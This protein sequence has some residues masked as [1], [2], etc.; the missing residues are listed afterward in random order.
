MFLV[1]IYY[2]LHKTINCHLILFDLGLH[3][4]E[5][6]QETSEKNKEKYDPVLCDE[7]SQHKNRL[8]IHETQSAVY[9][10]QSNLLSTT[11][12][13]TPM[14]HPPSSK[15]YSCNICNKK[16]D[17]QSKLRFHHMK[18]HNMKN[19][20]EY[21]KSN[22]VDDDKITSRQ[23]GRET[24]LSNAHSSPKCNERHQKKRDKMKDQQE[25]ERTSQEKVEKPC[26][27]GPK[28]AKKGV[29]VEL[30]ESKPS[31]ELEHQG[32]EQVKDK[33]YAT[34]I[35]KPKNMDKNSKMEVS[36]PND[37]PNLAEDP[38]ETRNKASEE[39]KDSILNSTED[40]EVKTEEAAD[41]NS[42]HN[43]EDNHH[44]ELRNAEEDGIKQDISLESCEENQ[45]LGHENVVESLEKTSGFSKEE[46]NDEEEFKMP[47]NFD[48]PDE[49]LFSIKHSSRTTV[50]NVEPT[51]KAVRCSGVSTCDSSSRLSPE[52][53]LVTEGKMA[54][55]DV[56]SNEQRISK[57]SGLSGNSLLKVSTF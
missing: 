25:I 15:T 27:V 16:F 39:T 20:T 34:I 48:L 56:Q 9:N 12:D 42:I 37:S 35:P 50:P 28:T 17:V 2:Q 41:A 43:C 31:I 53:K 4:V 13:T 5:E 52:H 55:L 1:I 36:I 44:D 45:E 14:S 46:S 49:F 26:N 22:Y 21:D 24:D 38:K 57:T 29:I 8:E 3:S 40:V 18:K 47:D 19:E 30:N 11:T 6:N 33:V 54:K 32:D 23:H 10:N 51:S 7:M